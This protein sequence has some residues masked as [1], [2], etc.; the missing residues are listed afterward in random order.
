M[1]EIGLV[2][3]VPSLRVHSAES[4]TRPSMRAVGGGTT[5]TVMVALPRTLAQP[6]VRKMSA[7]TARKKLMDLHGCIACFLRRGGV[8]QLFPCW[9]GPG[10]ELLIR[11]APL[12]IR[13]DD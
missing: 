1:S 10:L 6:W 9:Q 8:A 13:D 5:H 2:T 11:L 3:C 12:E 4:T 7:L